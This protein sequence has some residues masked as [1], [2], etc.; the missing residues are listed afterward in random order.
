MPQGEGELHHTIPRVAWSETHQYHTVTSGPCRTPSLEASAS[1]PPPPKSILKKISYPLLPLLEEAQREVTPEPS[2]PLS[3]LHYLDGPV[4]RVLQA[5]A[6]LRETIEAYSIL[7]ARVRA[8]AFEDPLAAAAGEGRREEAAVITLPSP[9]ESPRKKVGMSAEQVKHA[10]DLYTVSHAAMK[11]LALVFTLPAVSQV[12]TDKQLGFIL[13]QVLA[14]PLANEIPTPN[15][16]KTC[17]LAIWLIQIQRLSIEV[18]TPAVDRIAYALRR[19]IDGELGKEGKKGSTSDGLRAVHDLSLY[20]PALFAPAFVKLLPGVLSN[21]LAPT[22]GMR[23][24][25]CHALGGFTLALASLPSSVVHT[26]VANMISEYLALPRVEAGASNKPL[27]PSKDPAI[28]RTLRQTLQAT[29][30]TYAAQGPVW[31]WCVLANFIVLLGPA[32]YTVDR[33]TRTISALLSVGI[34]HQKS[35]VRGL[36]CV[37]WRCLTWAY[38]RPPPVKLP[39]MTEDE[40]GLEEDDERAQEYEKEDMRRYEQ[41]KENA[42]KI[43]MTIVEMG[44][45]V[46]TIGALLGDGMTEE[47]TLRRALSVLR[48]MTKTGSN[49]CLDALDMMCQLVSVDVEKEWEPYRLLPRGLFSVYPGLLTADYNSL[50]HAVRPV[51][52]QCLTIEDVRSLTRDELSIDWVFDE[53]L[54][55]WQSALFSQQWAWGDDIPDIVLTPWLGL[56]RA[57]VATLQDADDEEGTVTLALRATMVL[58]DILKD[59]QHDFSV[60]SDPTIFD[61]PTSPAIP[62]SSK[63]M[64]ILPEC[65]WGYA[66]KLLLVRELWSTVKAIFPKDALCEPAEKLVR[67]LNRWERH[68]VGDVYST[69]EVRQQWGYLCAEALFTCDVIELESFWDG[70]KSSRKRKFQRDW[71]EGVRC[72]VWHAFLEKWR[73]CTGSWEAAVVLLSVPFIDANAWEMSNDDLEAWDEFLRNTIDRALDYGV[74]SVTVVDQVAM[75]ISS[76]HAPASVSAT[77]V[78]DLLLSHLEIIEARQVPSDLFEFVNDILIWSYPPAPR[79]KVTIMWLIRSLTRIIDA[80]P[81]ELS[82]AMLELIQHGVCTWI[83]DDYEVC[84][85]DGYAMDILTLY[86]TILVSMQSLPCSMSVLEV[87]TPFLEAAFSGRADKPASVAQ[88]FDDFWNATYGEFPEPSSGWPDR[89]QG[90]LDALART[91]DI[92]RSTLFTASKAEKVTADADQEK[93]LD[94][95]DDGLDY[96]DS[97]D[98]IET[99]LLLPPSSPAVKLAACFLLSSPRS[100][101]PLFAELPSISEPPSTPK[102]TTRDLTPSTP[103]PPHKSSTKDYISLL[104]PQSPLIPSPSRTPVTPRRSPQSASRSHRR[105]RALRVIRRISPLPAIASFAERLAMR[106]PGLNVSSLG[107]EPSMRTL[108]TRKRPDDRGDMQVHM[109]LQ[110]SSRAIKASLLGDVSPTSNLADSSES[111]PSSSQSAILAMTPV[112]RK[113]K[114]AFFEAVEVPTFRDFLKF[115]RHSSLAFAAPSDRSVL[116]L[117]RTRSATKL[118]TEM[119]FERLGYTPKK[120]R[121]SDEYELEETEELE[122]PASPFVFSPLR[123]V[124]GS[125]MIGSDDSIMFASPTKKVDLPSDDDPH[126]GQVTPH[127]LVSPAIRRVQDLD[128]D[129]PSDDSNMSASP[130]REAVARKNVM[131]SHHLSKRFMRVTPLNMLQHSTTQF[132]SLESDL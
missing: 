87:L 101:S 45:G 43:V 30:P 92:P 27:S 28:V 51:A 76:N 68:L 19:G 91:Q 112:S 108:K 62:H 13:T 55:I 117:R 44:A 17:A 125:Q 93:L 69:D 132:S 106:S 32:L 65:R 90:C 12:F 4:T 9:K 20:Q 89:I 29:D 36:A 111:S 102:S 58:M 104:E 103:S 126:L 96:P 109:F 88:A 122:E 113:R 33:V 24:Q 83:M 22:T 39:A 38:F 105:V 14:I 49:A 64:K 115:R 73:E 67:T 57:N 37:V 82:Q 8:R 74:D 3:D 15:A 35:G 98:E 59:D 54:E 128:Y 95:A 123:A 97:E 107:K 48:D 21:L 6:S 52:D 124:R 120:L 81:V 70:R 16:R 50:G 34:R 1:K 114:S 5:D 72:V 75:A 118:S 46:A 2:D 79:N 11:F 86:Q 85:I 131:L 23:A 7:T 119:A 18:L 71:T 121:M 77:R 94:D 60:R 84:E 42:W 41:R 10:R 78:A 100:P 56:L 26:R 116:R 80:C 31:A 25:A 63:T 66:I 127:H 47:A 129:P 40:D 130:S 53:L 110:G 61:V 99:N